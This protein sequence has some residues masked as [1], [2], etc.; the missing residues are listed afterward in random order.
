VEVRVKGPTVAAGYHND[1]EK[2]AAAFD[3]EGF[4]KLGDAAGSSIRT[5]RPRAW[6]STAG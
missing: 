6:C 5:T 2:T 4:Y 1:P 3:E